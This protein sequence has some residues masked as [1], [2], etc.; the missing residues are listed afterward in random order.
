L[1]VLV[2]LPIFT[3][4][5]ISHSIN[6]H[7][8]KQNSELIEEIDEL[9]NDDA[10]EDITVTIDEDDQDRYTKEAANNCSIL[11]KNNKESNCLLFKLKCATFRNCS[12]NFKRRN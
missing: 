11:I 9:T 10:E 7:L 3:S 4:A 2:I 1:I 12:F 8:A 6:G 5:L